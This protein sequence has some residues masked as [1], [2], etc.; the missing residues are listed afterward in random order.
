VFLSP[1][2]VQKRYTEIFSNRSSQVSSLEILTKDRPQTPSKSNT[3]VSK[4]SRVTKST[5]SGAATKTQTAQTAERTSLLDISI[6]I[7]KAV[8]AQPKHLKPS[9]SRS[10]PTW[11]EKILMYDP[12]V[13]EDFTSWLNVEGLGL[14]GEDREIGTAAVREWCEAKGICCCWKKNANW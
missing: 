2:Q 14:V 8:R 11:H 9:N 5:S 13:L 6:Q 1:S 3:A 10:R 12:I 4:Y 7:T